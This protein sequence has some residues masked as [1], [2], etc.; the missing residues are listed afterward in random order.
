[1]ND[2]KVVQFENFFLVCKQEV[3]MFQGNI[4]DYTYSKEPEY[5]NCSYLT[6]KTDKQLSGLI[7]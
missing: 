5:V 2:Y 3:R 4:N 6:H 1:M 7:R